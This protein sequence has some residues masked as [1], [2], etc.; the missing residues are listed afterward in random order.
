MIFFLPMFIF[1]LK[2]EFVN[3]KFDE[4]VSPDVLSSFEDILSKYSVFM[5]Q[6]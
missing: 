1:Y 2:G 5:A 3:L 6:K 4:T